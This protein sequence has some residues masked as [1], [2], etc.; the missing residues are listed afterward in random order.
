[1]GADSALERTVE[2]ILKNTEQQLITSL[3][4]ALKSSQSTIA[5][6]QTSLEQEYDKI[7][8]EGKKEA[9][10][11]EKQII[12][13]A[14]L[15]SRNKQLLLVEESIEKVFEKAISKLQNADRGADYSKL[16]STLLQESIDV[17]GTP[18]IIVQ[19]NSKDASVV[20]S[21][22]SK[23]P[24]ATLSSDQ[25][26]CLGGIRVQSK[27]GTMKFDNTIDARLE[28]LKPLIR[29]DIASKFGR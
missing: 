13:N 9:E 26:D 8:A 23:F 28:R 12:G 11:L 20:Q 21:L 5:N 10:K 4:D 19:T 14:D 18:E 17:I 2:T 29:K 25:I 15:D 6:S 3:N 7:I 1:M 16:I 27:D 24:G 22:L